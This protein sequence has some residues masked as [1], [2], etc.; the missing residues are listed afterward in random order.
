MDD[1]TARMHGM[2]ELKKERMFTEDE[3]AEWDENIQVEISDINV[4][5]EEELIRLNSENPEITWMREQ[6]ELSR[7][8][9][10]GKFSDGTED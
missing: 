2:Y 9:L 6:E 1:W 7:L 8:F 10:E 3:L 5:I 4:M